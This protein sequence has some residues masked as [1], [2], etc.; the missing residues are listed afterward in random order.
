[1]ILLANSDVLQGR[2]VIMGLLGQGGF[3]AVY[4]A[5]DLR[6]P[7]RRVAIK[8]NIDA[9]PAVQA[10]FQTEATLLAAL[11]HSNLPSVTDFFVAQS[12]YQYLVMDFIEGE[13][14]EEMVTSQGPLTEA[15]AVAWIGQVLDALEYLHRQNPPIIHR[16]VKP[17][18]VKI[19]PQ[20][21][22]IL[23]DFGI[24]KVNQAG[25][26]TGMGARAVSAG[27]SPPEQYGGG[28]TDAR[29]DVYAA[30]ATL[31][32]ALTGQVPTESVSRLAG[33]SLIPAVQLNPG[34]SAHI[35]QV[36]D[37]AMALD[38][39]HRFQNAAA[40][41]MALARPAVVLKPASPTMKVRARPSLS[42]RGGLLGMLMLALL[43]A[44]LIL[45]R[46]GGAL[47]SGTTP[48]PGPSVTPSATSPL[49]AL[50][51]TIPAGGG[52]PA[53]TVGPTNT[54]SVLPTPT[55]TQPATLT[56]TPTSTASATLM[57]P[58]P[59]FQGQIAFASNRDGFSDLYVVDADGRN[60]RRLTSNQ[61]YDW[62][63]RW[64]P[65]GRRLA[66]VANPDGQD[67]VYIM[68]VPSRQITRLT[69]DTAKDNYPCW[70]PDGRSIAFSSNLYGNWDIFVINADGRNRR[71]L[72][73]DRADDDYPRFAP[74]GQTIVFT[75]S[76]DGLPQ[77]YLMHA[78]GSQQR[79][80]VETEFGA[81]EPDWSPRGDRIVFAGDRREPF[82]YGDSLFLVNQ[83]GSALT[84]L[85]A[86]GGEFPAW[87][88]DG[89]YVIYLAN[90]QGTLNLWV[91][92]ADG[93][94]DHRITQ[95]SKTDWSPTWCCTP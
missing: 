56:H 92:G 22:A 81:L 80:L 27:Y 64:A 61:T 63:P 15:Q 38:A 76:R 51:T 83:A 36:L 90:R 35:C 52:V 49:E 5:N 8:E 77:L 33:L 95:G 53:V 94:D 23:V 4:L 85:T 18:N 19:N 14:L 47:W 50:P 91:I 6:L 39:A 78:D 68:D 86:D 65:D 32:F 40:F 20:G 54:R 67:D 42:R 58:T 16:D 12:G 41:K 75:S 10:Q 7:G 29:T 87:S 3:G 13:T 2:Y 55:A 37:Q 74:D 21:Q 28:T 24:A 43:G 89:S 48:T 82:G 57:R 72:T 46:P 11:K 69:R 79:R 62:A 71:Q 45:A 30:G 26:Q 1:M 60:M 9:S 34:L 66:F 17:A 70:T 44:G 31:Y 25:Q 59:P 88:P 73:D 93:Q 84:E